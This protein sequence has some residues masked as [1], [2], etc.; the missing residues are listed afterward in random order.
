MYILAL[1]ANNSS[2]AY[3]DERG[4]WQL[5]DDGDIC[6]AQIFHILGLFL[7]NVDYL[8][9]DINYV[10]LISVF[11]KFVFKEEDSIEDDD[12]C[13]NDDTDDRP[14]DDD[15]VPGAGDS[16]SK[17]LSSNIGQA[18]RAL[19]GSSNVKTVLGIRSN[20]VPKHVRLTE[21]SLIFLNAL[22]SHCSGIENC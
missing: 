16:N 11:P 14:D 15:K 1:H 7:D 10:H 3:Q 21:K 12:I 5:K 20:N 19:S 22:R 8:L 6:Y 4:V 9:Q 17:N 2:R 13:S 18:A